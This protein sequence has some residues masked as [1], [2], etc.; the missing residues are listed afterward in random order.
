[1]RIFD[2]SKTVAPSMVG[3]GKLLPE[4]EKLVSR[5]NQH[6]KSQTRIFPGFSGK[7]KTPE[8]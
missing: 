7:W 1:M 6:Q 8:N 3:N 4:N 5:K 2:R